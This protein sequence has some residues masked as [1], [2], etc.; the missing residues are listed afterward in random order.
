MVNVIKKTKR[1][2]LMDQINPEK[3]DFLTA[4]GDVRGLE[5]L[6]ADKI[7]EINDHLLVRSSDEILEKFEPTVYCYFNANSQKVVYQL[8]KPAHRNTPKPSE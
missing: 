6:W 4:V 3:L 7:E 8:D 5:S 2:M 1:T